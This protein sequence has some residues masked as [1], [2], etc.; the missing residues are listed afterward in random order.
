MRKFNKQGEFCNITTHISI[1]NTFSGIIRNFCF[2]F[3]YNY[4]S[5]KHSFLIKKKLLYSFSIKIW[6]WLFSDLIPVLFM[7]KFSEGPKNENQSPKYWD[8]VATV[9][10]Q[11]DWHLNFPCEAHP[12][13]IVANTRS[14]CTVFCHVPTE[15]PCSSEIT[16]IITF[17]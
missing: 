16:S 6:G 15:I 5:L 2:I 8:N 17:L 3:Q 14:P 1:R 7:Q 9:R 11:I 10:N 12:Q 13:L 4:H